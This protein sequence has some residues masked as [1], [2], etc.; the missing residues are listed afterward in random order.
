MDDQRYELSLFADYFQ[1]YICDE[2]RKTDTGTI[3][4]Q[5]TTDRML[6]AGPDLVAV[7]TARNMTVPVT[8]EILH[9]QPSADV[10]AWDQVIECPL[11]VTSG[12]ILALGCTD[13]MEDSQHFAVPPGDY[14]VRVSYANLDDHSEDGLD[15]N[16]HYRVQ[17]WPGHVEQIHVIKRRPD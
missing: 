13:S 10:A 5:L 4:D 11:I 15:G 17:L 16:D 8:L 9:E 3:W 6:A 7:G 14:A 1:F 2:E 12:T